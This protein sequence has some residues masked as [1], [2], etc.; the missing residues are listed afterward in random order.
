MVSPEVGEI[1]EN[2][3]IRTIISELGKGRDTQRMMAEM[4]SQANT[5]RIK[6]VRPYTTA[7]GKLLT[8]HINKDKNPEAG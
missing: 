7:A 3:V 4:W 1:D 8:L 6:R 5:L 2:E